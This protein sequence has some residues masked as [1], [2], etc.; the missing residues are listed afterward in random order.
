MA[1]LTIP[2]PVAALSAANDGLCGGL[3]AALPLAL[4]S[5]RV[6]VISDF[7]CPYCF[8]LNEW[9]ASMGLANQVRWVGVEHKP[10]LPSGFG[11]HNRPDDLTTLRQEVSDV[12]VRAPEVGVI[13]PPVWVNSHRALLMQAALEDEAPELAH[14]F[15]QEVFR[16]FWCQSRDI[17]AE[18]ELQ[19][20]L[21]VAG[22]TLDDGTFFDEQELASI[23]SWWQ[24]ELDRI[25]CLLA[26][27]GARHLGL[28]DRRAVESF[29]LGALRE[30]P[31]GA[32]CQ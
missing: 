3:Q 5:A 17:S 31:P 27:T 13:L 32:G 4:L 7:N 24:Q 11:E 18:A 23:T 29:V 9:L 10:H 6:V 22:V 21:E 1:F 8:T 12:R 19:A 14:R 20:A 2:S 26:P 25:P 16:R 28:Q 30:G 15:R